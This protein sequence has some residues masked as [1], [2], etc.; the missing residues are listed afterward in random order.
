MNKNRVCIITAALIL[1][2]FF[3]AKLLAAPGAPN[4]FAE[5]KSA[6]C[7][8]GSFYSFSALRDQVDASQLA[9]SV[10]LAGFPNQEEM[11][12][13]S[14]AG[15]PMHYL[16]LVDQSTS[17]QPYRS[18]VNAFAGSL[19][20][21]AGPDVTYSVAEIGAEFAVRLDA[22]DDA[23]LFSQA[24][25]ELSYEALASNI[26]GGIV[27][28]LNYLSANPAPGGTLT[29]LVILTDGTPYLPASVE[30]R[31]AILAD[32]AATAGQ[33]LLETPETLVHPITFRTC[34]AQTAL[35]LQNAAGHHAM[36]QTQQQAR[37][38]AD[39]LL[40]TVQALYVTSCS[41]D[42]TSSGSRQPVQIMV[43]DSTNSVEL[44]VIQ[45]I[46]MLPISLSAPSATGIPLEPEPEPGT[47]PEPEP[48]PEPGTEPEPGPETEPEPG[49]ETETEAET[50]TGPETEPEAEVESE[51]EAE[52]ASPAAAHEETPLWWAIGLSVLL[53]LVLG[54]II[55][56]CIRLLKRKS[57]YG[58]P[59]KLDILTGSLAKACRVYY[60][61]EQLLIGSGRNCDMIWKSSTIPSVCARLSLKDHVLYLESCSDA[62]EITVSGMRVHGISRLRS[63][64]IVTIGEIAFRLLF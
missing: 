15:S 12:F 58:I 16:L 23:T 29:N 6:Y 62:A 49:P 21:S 25:Q 22:T 37:D 2:L 45:D 60:L 54:G 3:P 11:Q 18:L 48:E 27:D 63:G 31:E 39:A 28:A 17:M 61:D 9:V 35:A 7:I 38:A 40:S 5:V 46:A 1:F 34:E 32:A 33:A 24:V 4:S 36:V 53:A 20:A 52:F 55:L 19:A 44:S 51:A 26:C 64:D 56:G 30:D 43:T 14:A 57:Q 47:E 8:D 13:A 41:L 10:T 59:V 42:N 50:E